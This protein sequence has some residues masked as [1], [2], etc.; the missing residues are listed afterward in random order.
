MCTVEVQR[1]G[2][3][4]DIKGSILEGEREG[5][6]DLCAEGDGVWHRDT[7]NEGRGHEQIGE[8]GT[9]DG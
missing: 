9:Y 3:N 2:P 8:N 4:P 6:Q 7:A 5:I 1:A